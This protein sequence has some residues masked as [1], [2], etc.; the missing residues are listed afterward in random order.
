MTTAMFSPAIKR[1]YDPP[2]ASDGMRILVDRLWPR[3]IAKAK[4][5][6]DLW[7][8]DISPSEAL[9]KKFHGREDDWEE[10]RKAYFAELKSATAQAAAKI[11]LDHLR[12]GP[13]TLIY[14]AR[15]EQHNN[16]V[17]LQAW[18]KRKTR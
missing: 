15:D 6:I 7:L 3:G 4:A 16:A 2:A 10:F 11:L 12:S 14:A 13:V 8:K 18:L 1:A 17:A 9:R 5:K